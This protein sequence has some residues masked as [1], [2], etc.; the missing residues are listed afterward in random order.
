MRTK[1]LNS[2]L[3]GMLWTQIPHHPV[4]RAAGILGCS[5]SQVYNCLNDQRLKGVR[6]GGRTLVTTESIL[7][8]LAKAKPWVPDK[9][10][11]RKAIRARTSGREPSRRAVA[12]LGKND[13]G[14]QTRGSVRRLS[15][16]A[17]DRSLL[18]LSKETV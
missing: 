4:Q 13:H 16:K 5:P 6:L 14:P 17:S 8:L 12:E 18:Q 9:E 1:T 3:H 15:A 2:S 11:V 7:A 10:R